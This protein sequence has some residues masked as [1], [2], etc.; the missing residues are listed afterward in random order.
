MLQARGAKVTTPHPIDLRLTEPAEVIFEAKVLG[1]FSPVLAIRSAV[2]QLFEYRTFIGPKHSSLCIL[3]DAD[4][5]KALTDYVENDLGL[6]IS[7]L[8][9]DGFYGGPRTV[10]RLASL[11]LGSRHGEQ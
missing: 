5:G 3:L 2:G 7:W 6:L 4:P 1:R 11:E 10:A 8:T 9:A